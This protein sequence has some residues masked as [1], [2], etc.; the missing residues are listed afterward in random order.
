MT[1]PVW[2]LLAFATWTLLTLI[3]TVGVYR[4]IQILLGRMP[5]SSWRADGAQG[6]DWYRRGMRAHA[7][8]VENLP[9]YGALVLVMVAAG[10]RDDRLDLLAMALMAARVLHTLVHVAL[11]Q[12]NAVAA[13]RFGFFFIQV[14]CMMSMVAIIVSVT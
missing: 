5:I 9:V 6:S 10:V 4:W 1:I 11:P 2:V 8:C 3:A 7:N 12:T 13:V 14:L